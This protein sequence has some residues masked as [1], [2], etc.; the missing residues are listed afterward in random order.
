MKT[1]N[2]FLALGCVLFFYFELLLY[3]YEKEI[4]S[5]SPKNAVLLTAILCMPLLIKQRRLIRVLQKPIVKWIISFQVLLVF[6]YLLTKVNHANEYG[7]LILESFKTLSLTNILMFLLVIVL[8]DKAVFEIS[9]KFLIVAVIA[10]CLLNAYDMLSFDI[11]SFSEFLGRGAGTYMNP[12]LSYM[13]IMWGLILSINSIASRYRILYM[14]ICIIGVCF[15]LSRGGI[16]LI[17][18]LAILFIM[19]KIFRL[20]T[21]LIFIGTISIV[22]IVGSQTIYSNI[23]KGIQSSVYNSDALLNRFNQ[24]V[25]PSVANITGDSRFDNLAY[26]VNR[27]LENPIVGNGLGSSNYFS[28]YYIYKNTSHNQFIHFLNELGVMG[29][30]II[31]SF[32]I[33]LG[34]NS[35]NNIVLSKEYILFIFTFITFAFFSHNLMDHYCMAY[36]YVFL[37]RISESKSKTLPKIL[38]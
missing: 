16:V 17:F 18:L 8:D 33:V 4:I 14:S 2:K 35:N 9:K 12:N 23:S 29:F 30:I 37:S 32:L 22:A 5:F 31:I 36:C 11:E 7:V 15:T 19:F 20:K 34:I 24:I 28:K 38:S 6:F 13:A 3:T 10:A 25:N 21:S 27:Y 1:Y 26:Y